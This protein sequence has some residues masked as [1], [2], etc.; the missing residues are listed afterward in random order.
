MEEPQTAVSALLGLV[1]VAYCH[2]NCLSVHHTDESQ[3]GQNGAVC[4]TSIFVRTIGEV[5]D[6]W[7]L[8]YMSIGLWPPSLTYTTTVAG[9]IV[10]HVPV[11][12]TAKCN[13]FMYMR[14]HDCVRVRVCA[15]LVHRPFFFFVQRSKLQGTVSKP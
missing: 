4:G 12:T 15:Y 5:I 6:H 7:L 11:T 9:C 1:S 10:R 3:Q 8:I 14:I 2:P 13:V